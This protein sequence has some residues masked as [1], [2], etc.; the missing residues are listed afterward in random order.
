MVTTIQ[1]SDELK[2]ELAK[3]KFSDRETYENIIWDLLEDAM[4]LNEETKKE[5]EQSREEIKAGKVQSLAQIK[6]ELKIK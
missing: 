5:L 4:E 6:K 3:K 2:K 1:I